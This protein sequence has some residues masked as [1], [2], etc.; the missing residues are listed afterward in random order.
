MACLAR[1]TSRRSCCRCMHRSGRQR[2][3]SP[4]RVE[5]V[6]HP[7]GRSLAGKPQRQ[8]LTSSDL[9]CCVSNAR[10]ALGEPVKGAVGCRLVLAPERGIPG[11][12]PRRDLHDPAVFAHR[13][14]I[15]RPLSRS[16]DITESPSRDGS[17]QRQPRDRGVRRRLARPAIKPPWSVSRSVSICPATAPCC[18][19][20]TPNT[21]WLAVAGSGAADDAE[22][23]LL[24]SAPR[25]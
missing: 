14:S 10:T 1:A 5:V 17:C 12:D 22:Q 4:L 7:A 16:R 21:R 8:Q 15:A 18:Q 3:H 11:L 19:L 24:V 6:H 9:A 20:R 23:P 25:Q 13:P 2:D